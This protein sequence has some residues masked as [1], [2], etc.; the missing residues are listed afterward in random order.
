MSKWSANTLF[1]VSDTQD[2]PHAPVP[3]GYI[4]RQ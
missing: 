3:L 2:L 4:N 1:D